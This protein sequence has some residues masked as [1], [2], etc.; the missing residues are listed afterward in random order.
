MKDI[1]I[2]GLVIKDEKGFYIAKNDKGVLKLNDK[3]LRAYFAAGKRIVF[4]GE[5]VATYQDVKNYMFYYES[6][7]KI[8]ADA[9]NFFADFE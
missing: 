4:G 6:E 3:S 1:E 5:P 2:K 8:L 7:Q 9:N